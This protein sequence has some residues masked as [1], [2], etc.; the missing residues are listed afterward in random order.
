MTNETHTLKSI[1][2]I[3]DA[4]VRF[5]DLTVLVG[6]QASGKSIFLQFLKLVLDGV[7]VRATLRKHGLDWVGKNEFLDLYLGEGMRSVWHRGNSKV[8]W[9]NRP[10]D[11]D[12]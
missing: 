4:S 9:R 5:G 3:K 7:P 6:P 8:V 12:P 11:P 10:I 1:G 2:P